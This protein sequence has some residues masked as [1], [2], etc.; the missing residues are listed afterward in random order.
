M[1]RQRLE[2][3]L[4][5][6]T[7]ARLDEV[8]TIELAR[9]VL[10]LTGGAP[11]GQCTD[12][13]LIAVARL[14]LDDEDLEDGD[15]VE[16]EG[17]TGTVRDVLGDDVVVE[18]DDGGTRR[19]P[20][21]DCDRIDGDW[22][23]DNHPRGENG[24]FGEGGGGSSKTVPLPAH[25]V[26]G[27]ELA[28]HIEGHFGAGAK[29][30][31]DKKSEVWHVEHGGSKYEAQVGSDDDNLSFSK[32]GSQHEANTSA[33][34]KGGGASGGHAAAAQ[35]HA[36]RARAAAKGT[37]ASA[38]ASARK[39]EEHSALAQAAHAA[40]NH[41]AAAEHAKQAET[42]AGTAVARATEHRES[43]QKSAT[44]EAKNSGGDLHQ[45]RMEKTHDAS[46]APPASKAQ[47][48]NYEKFTKEHEPAIKAALA[49]A[50]GAGAQK[51]GSDNSHFDPKAAIAASDSFNDRMANITHGTSASKG[52]TQAYAAKASQEAAASST[53]AHVASKGVTPGSM[54]STAVQRMKDNTRAARAHG[55]ASDNHLR[56]AGLH[57]T[58]G[59]S[60]K[61]KEHRVTAAQHQEKAFA[62]AQKGDDS[63]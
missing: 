2:T 62:H 52:I 40:G 34:A 27:K 37:N 53:A 30:S 56:A 10:A 28:T 60:D 13:G 3:F 39:A 49:K 26:N 45:E 9:R 14:R 36:E 51:T 19:Y 58:V 54:P 12:A 8:A 21:D 47:Q 57:D 23:E 15:R 61:A 46:K 16:C 35:G 22:D 29:A 55:K 42:H 32:T 41:A 18:L 38:R 33:I 31:F 17:G 48:A 6:K 43:V 1:I 7:Q 11:Q 44:K 25:E 5:T 24:Q 63:I 20:M 59:N 50:E 4:K